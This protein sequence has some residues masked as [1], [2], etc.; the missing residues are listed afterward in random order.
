MISARRVTI[1]PR[2]VVLARRIREWFMAKHRILPLVTLFFFGILQINTRIKIILT[3]MR[4]KTLSHPTL[5]KGR[6]RLAA[7]LQ[8][9]C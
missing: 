1:M 9:C 8:K 2:D 3:K 5:M 6:R 4:F 7:D